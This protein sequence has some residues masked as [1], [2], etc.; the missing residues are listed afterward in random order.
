[1]AVKVSRDEL[2]QVAIN[3][4]MKRGERMEFLLYSDPESFRD[5]ADPFLLGS[6]AE[7]NLMVGIVQ[8]LCKQGKTTFSNS[9]QEPVLCAVKDGDKVRAL[10]VMTPPYNLVLSE[11]QSEAIVM[12]AENLSASGYSLPGFLGPG[13]AASE[14]REAWGSV[15]GQKAELHRSMGV[16]ELREVNPITGVSG[17]CELAVMDE[18]NLVTEWNEAF[19]REIDTLPPGNIK[20][21]IEGGSVHLWKDPDP[22]S[23]AVAGSQTVNG[24]RVGGV[25]T[26][27]EFRR[28]GY[29]SAVTA[30]VSQFI[31]DSG[32][33]F[34][35]LF[36]DLANP[37]SNHIYQEIGYK[38]VCDF[39]EYQF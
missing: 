5:A 29:A 25:Y 18:L 20:A 6:E 13:Y 34:C 1:V 10:A 7:N 31:L 28:H 9:G 27:P 30:A 11:G 35:Y 16:Y 14:F 2:V 24:R 37:T 39:D 3:A 8:S 36:A 23:M 17:H 15:T 19:A 12:M 33:K 22:V 26:P 38:P 4:S 32:K 21:L